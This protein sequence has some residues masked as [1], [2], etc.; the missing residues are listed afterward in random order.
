MDWI[1]KT[2]FNYWCLLQFVCP[3]VE[4]IVIIYFDFYQRILQT[5]AECSEKILLL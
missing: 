2:I 3:S 4:Y 1:V 5:K